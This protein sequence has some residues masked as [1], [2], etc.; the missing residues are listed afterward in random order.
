MEGADYAW[1]E[2]FEVAACGLDRISGRGC[3][4]A[5]PGGLDRQRRGWYRIPSVYI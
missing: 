1:M 3:C 4:T 2:H 5:C